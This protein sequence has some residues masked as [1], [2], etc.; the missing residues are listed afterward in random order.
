MEANA[1]AFP[2]TFDRWDKAVIALAFVITFLLMLPLAAI[3]IC[4]HHDGIMLKPALDVAAGQT[5]FKDTFTQYGA[6]TTYLQAGALLVFGRKLLVLKLLTVFAYAMTASL[7]VAIWRI[8]LPRTL[9][10]IA[11][12]VWLLFLPLFN[13][14]M[15]W[16][17]LP[18]SSVYALLFQ[19]AAL[20]LFLKS[21]NSPGGA[22]YSL[23]SGICAALVCWCRQPVGVFLIAA[24]VAAHALGCLAGSATKRR[25]IRG[26][27]CVAG[28]VGV[29]SLFVFHLL[30]TNAFQDWYFQNVEWPRVWVTTRGSRT[31][32]AVVQALCP[33]WGQG[34]ALLIVL[35]A[36]LLPLRLVTRLRQT[37]FSWGASIAFWFCAV[38]VLAR[39]YALNHFRMHPNRGH[40]QWLANFL[41]TPTLWPR[42]G[43][44]VAIPGGIALATAIALGALLFRSVRAK[45]V[46]LVVVSVNLVCLASWLQYYPVCCGMHMCWAISPAIGPFLLCGLNLSGR[47]GY[48]V[49]VL[50][51]LL[52]LPAITSKVTLYR[53]LLSA[54]YVR[55]HS[56]SVLAGMRVSESFAGE[57]QAIDKALVNYSGPEKKTPMLLESPNGLYG[58]LVSDLRNPGPFHVLWTFLPEPDRDNKR[59]NFIAA[60]KPVIFVEP[61]RDAFLGPVIE[62]WHYKS[63]LRLQNGI[64]L[65]A[66]S[67]TP[68]ETE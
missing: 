43:W 3:G 39:C 26:L 11:F 14:S 5:L 64:E 33:L 59:L 61:R 1:P 50:L 31:V 63:L 12:I 6:L 20:L 19:S 45:G 37:R 57:I 16:T 27:Y 52:L 29:S 23:S 58:A 41:L 4:P 42:G 15:P 8:L 68:Q 48:A 25:L 55:L 18:W 30:W 67:E 53:Q 35:V 66:P 28:F 17:L 34:V 60:E 65:L 36:L 32:A 49:T 9:T 40:T 24:L 7:L 22:G 38:A 62:R 44:A 51:I 46:M 2:V 10:V 54:P 56:P 47:R 21:L 13:E